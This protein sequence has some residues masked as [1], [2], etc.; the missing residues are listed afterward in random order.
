MARTKVI[1]GPITAFAELGPLAGKK[2]STAKGAK[3]FL[4]LV[5]TSSAIDWIAFRPEDRTLRIKFESG[6]LYEYY[7]VDPR[8]VDMLARAGSVGRTFLRTIRDRYA[9]ARVG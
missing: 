1:T 8:V 7:S 3:G 2:R 9:Y 6:S 5:V 4:R